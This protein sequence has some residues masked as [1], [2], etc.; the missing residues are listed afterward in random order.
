MASCSR[1][2]LSSRQKIDIITCIEK[3][4]N[5]AN[6]SIRRNLSKAKVC[7]I[8]KN[9]ETLKRNFASAQFTVDCKRFRPSIQRDVDAALL[10]WFK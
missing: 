8:W 3:G 9:R 7:T 4:E 5:Q 10:E 1:Q 2:P 6:L